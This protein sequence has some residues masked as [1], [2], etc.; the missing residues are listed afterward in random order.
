MRHLNGPALREAPL[1]PLISSAG[2]VSLLQAIALA[3]VL[4]VDVVTRGPLVVPLFVTG[5]AV[6]LFWENLFAF[7]RHADFSFHGLTTAMLV[8][9]FAPLGVEAWQL[10]VAVSLGVVLGELVF[11][12]RGFGFVNPAAAS[13]ALLVFSFPQL[14]LVAPE[15]TVA[16]A[17][18]PG[19]ILLLIAGLISWRVLLATSLI[20]L[21]AVGFTSTIWEPVSLAITLS[22]GIVFLIADPVSAACTNPGRWAYGALAGFL[23]ALFAGF[24]LENL[25]AEAVVFAALL[26]SLF[27]PLI[28]HLMV[29]T[30]AYNRKRR[31]ARGVH[32]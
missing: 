31:H 14:T 15:L 4:A 30:N 5:L 3:P 27:A 1:L 28:D 22:V 25:T 21:A 29:L 8:T 18:L 23:T 17:T 19:A 13:L 26:A 24:S 12:G 20:A 16:L 11:G 7:L 2:R 6:A 32:G 10:A 9:L